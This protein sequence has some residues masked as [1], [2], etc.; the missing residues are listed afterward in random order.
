MNSCQCEIADL[1]SVYRQDPEIK[2][3]SELLL[4]SARYCRYDCRYEY[5]YEYR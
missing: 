1:S 5:R 3:L 4:I 2:L